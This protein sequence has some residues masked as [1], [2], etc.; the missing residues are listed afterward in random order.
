MGAAGLRD[1]KLAERV[2]NGLALLR[3]LLGSDYPEDTLAE[4]VQWKRLLRF[5]RAARKRDIWPKV[6]FVITYIEPQSREVRAYRW[7]GVQGMSGVKEAVVKAIGSYR[8]AAEALER[9]DQELLK[10]G[11]GNLS[12]RP[13]VSRRLREIR[14]VLAEELRFAGGVPEL[15]IALG[16]PR[17]E[18]RL[19]SPALPRI[20]SYS[21]RCSSAVADQ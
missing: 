8:E 2:N 21:S 7:R 4:P 12:L 1:K 9:V 5:A 10:V 11:S 6:R 18:E 17:P 15:L 19:R 13:D 3:E 20:Q 14:A 16:T